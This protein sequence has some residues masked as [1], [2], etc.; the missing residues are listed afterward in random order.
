MPDVTAPTMRAI[1]GMRADAGG[2]MS[3]TYDAV[4]IG[5]GAL[6]TGAYGPG[7]IS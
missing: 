4:V 6:L 2:R 1:S 5:G 7:S 3:E